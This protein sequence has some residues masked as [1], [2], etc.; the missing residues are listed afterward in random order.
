MKSSSLSGICKICGHAN[1][2]HTKEEC[3]ARGCQK[4]IKVCGSTA[5][6]IPEL[7][8]PNCYSWVVCAQCEDHGRVG[9]HNDYSCYP[10]IGKDRSGNLVIEEEGYDESLAT[11]GASCV[12]LW[13]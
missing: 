6:Y 8:D 3:G 11:T 9:K 5:H 1:G 13:N 2:T 12:Q 4:K 10:L 7:Q